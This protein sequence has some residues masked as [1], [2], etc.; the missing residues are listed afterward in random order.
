MILYLKQYLS[1]TYYFTYFY[2]GGG[3]INGNWE[4]VIRN[5]SQRIEN[6]G[7]GKVFLLPVKIVWG[8]SGALILKNNATHL[9]FLRQPLINHPILYRKKYMFNKS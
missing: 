1:K 3:V 9:P 8:R 7:F 5:R 2:W 4:N 6:L